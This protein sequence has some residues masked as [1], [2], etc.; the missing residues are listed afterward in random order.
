[1]RA[2]EFDVPGAV[3]R[4][5]GFL[6][7]NPSAQ[8]NANPAVQQYFGLPPTTGQGMN[9]QPLPAG[10]G[11][12]TMNPLPLPAGGD[13]GMGGGAGGYFPG[14]AP[15]PMGFQ[16]QSFYDPYA[17]YASQLPLIQ[18]GMHDNLANAMAGAGFTGNRFGTSAQRLAAQ[19][20]VRASNQANA[21]LMQ[22]LYGQANA[23]Q[24]RALQATA[25]SMQLGGL[26][27]QMNQNRFQALFPMAQWE[28]A[29]QDQMARF[30]YDDWYRRMMDPLQLMNQFFGSQGSG[31]GGTPIQTVTNPGRP[32]AADTLGAILPIL[33]GLFGG[34]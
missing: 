23:D 32:G 5:Q 29:R 17:L 21:L 31:S 27:D 8:G 28:Q 4:Y 34:G 30:Y 15:Q 20:G 18:Q 22:T 13:W 2:G 11:A 24:D 9:P 14:Q 16:Q 7:S 19:E 25:Q 1:M 10:G 33:T 26:L 6:G 3:Q 12:A